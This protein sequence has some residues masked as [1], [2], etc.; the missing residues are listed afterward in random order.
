MCSSVGVRSLSTAARSGCRKARHSEPAGCTA[1]KNDYFERLEESR[2]DEHD[3]R[4]N[5]KGW[6]ARALEVGKQILHTCERRV[7][8]VLPL[9]GELLLPTLA[10]HHRPAEQNRQDA[11]DPVTP[12]HVSDASETQHERRD[13]HQYSDDDFRVFG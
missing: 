6:S 13:K 8:G 9:A 11:S 10:E 3:A 5:P 7:A 4:K 2:A 1:R 12:R